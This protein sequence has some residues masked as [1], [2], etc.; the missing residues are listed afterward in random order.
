MINQSLH[1][2]SDLRRLGYVR[3]LVWLSSPRTNISKNMLIQKYRKK[4]I[5]NRKSYN[6]NY[7]LESEISL[8]GVGMGKV[9]RRAERDSIAQ[10]HLSLAQDL[11]FIRK[12][13]YS[14]TKNGYILASLSCE[15][16]GSFPYYEEKS[17]DKALERNG[18]IVTLS[19]GEKLV[20]STSLISNDFDRILP[21]M[22]LLRNYSERKLIEEKYLEYVIKWFEKKEEIVMSNIERY[23]LRSQK[24][25]IELKSE[26]LKSELEGKQEKQENTL[27]PK[28]TRRKKPSMML[29]CR[30]QTSPRIEF[31]KDIGYV[32]K[33]SKELKL[34]KTGH[35]FL[36]NI[37]SSTELIDDMTNTP[38]YNEIA[39]LKKIV[40]VTKDNKPESKYNDFINSFLKI[41]KFYTKS[42]TLLLSYLNTYIAMASDASENDQYLPLDLYDIYLD[43]I[44]TEK[45]ITVSTSGR[46]T[47]Y[48]KFRSF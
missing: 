29:Y 7:D 36:E 19:P 39:L 35:E 17:L 1:L 47:R 28:N 26:R 40:E 34:T 43:Q 27:Q 8:S 33:V 9:E 5:N 42:G 4:I 3:L 16:D 31:L 46:G 48:I 12:D 20:F 37:Q 10:H 25:E 45:N 23:K 18:F 41:G 11:E 14:W 32:S 6:W 24:K 44:K 30:E 2:S 22:E 38:F 13:R 21:V 15:E